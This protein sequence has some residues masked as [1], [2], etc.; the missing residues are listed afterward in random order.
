[1]C[2]NASPGQVPVSNPAWWL[3]E[4]RGR[5]ASEVSGP[6]GS[7]CCT[8]KSRSD[9]D[10]SRG[11]TRPGAA[12]GSLRPCRSWCSPLRLLRQEN[13]P[14]W[15]R[16][17]RDRV[18]PEEALE[19]VRLHAG[20]AI[21]RY[22][23]GRE[24]ADHEVRF[25]AVEPPRYRVGIWLRVRPSYAVRAIRDAPHETGLLE[26]SLPHTHDL[27]PHLAIAQAPGADE[28]FPASR[29]HS[30]APELLRPWLTRPME[31]TRPTR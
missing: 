26:L 9:F 10:A 5:S 23:S 21:G 11:R 15:A 29:A 20:H 1:M 6:P 12:R 19:V 22:A 16:L 4:Q 13:P 7:R 17:R 14:S 28:R 24:R 18:E 8:A 2:K 30:A 31:M 25:F 3:R 27:I